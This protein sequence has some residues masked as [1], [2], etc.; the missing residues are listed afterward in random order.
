MKEEVDRS[1]AEY[2]KEKKYE[3]ATYMEDPCKTRR[4]Y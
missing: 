4:N 1:D 2:R 3:N